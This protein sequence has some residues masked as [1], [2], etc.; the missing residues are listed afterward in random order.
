MY[1]LQKWKN[2]RELYLKDDGR[3][4]LNKMNFLIDL[5]HINFLKKGEEGDVVSSNPGSAITPFL[6][7]KQKG[8]AGLAFVIGK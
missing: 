5:C 6:E 2:S 7:E 3:K 4:T 8:T 1:E